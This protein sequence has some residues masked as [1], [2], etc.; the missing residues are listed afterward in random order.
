MAKL[1]QILELLFYLIWIP[2]GLLLV[3]GAIFIILANPLAKLE[4]AFPAGGYGQGGPP[5]GMSHG[6][7]DLGDESG[8]GFDRQG[9]FGGPGPAGEFGQPR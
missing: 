3:A 8:Q 9:E 1:N 6:S 4:G 5:P 2:L 7:E